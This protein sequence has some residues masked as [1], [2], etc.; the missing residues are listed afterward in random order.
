MVSISSVS[1]TA[2]Q[3]AAY[4]QVGQIP[5]GQE[6][7]EQRLQRVRPV[8]QAPRTER[9]VEDKRAK[10]VDAQDKR[11]QA[12]QALE[13]KAD[14]SQLDQ[15]KQLASRDREVRAHE[16]AH[17]AAAGSYGGAIRFEYQRGPDGNR[18]A[19]GGEVDIDTSP[20]SS[21]EATL[22]KART[23]QRA[24]NAPAQPSDQDRAVAAQA[25]QMVQQALQQIAE[26]RQVESR[27][28]SS[29]S[30][31]RADK[32]ASS[33]TFEV[34]L[35]SSPAPGDKPVQEPGKATKPEADG[36]TVA[37]LGRERHDKRL[38]VYTGHDVARTKFHARA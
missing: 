20:E 33:D 27:Q 10:P 15:L 14:Q 2:P 22:A 32:K 18:Y 29:R 30:V 1:F 28:E 13:Q 19:V 3:P 34:E 37:T 16:L 5:V 17:K 26:S 11:Q 31:E 6:T 23:I 38:D 12:Q 36:K 9:A 24:A 4:T 21:P 8:E 25:V 7:G 35:K